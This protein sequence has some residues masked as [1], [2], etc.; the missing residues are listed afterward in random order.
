[1]KKQTI[2]KNCPNCKGEG[3]ISYLDQWDNEVK[4][5]CIQCQGT[6]KIRRI[7]TGEGYFKKTLL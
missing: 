3:V 6:G 2:Y 5:E 4:K 1:M 7:E